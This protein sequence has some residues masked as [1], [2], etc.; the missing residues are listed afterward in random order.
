[1]IRTIS[2]EARA[3]IQALRD[4]L[5]LEQYLNSMWDRRE[6]ENPREAKASKGWPYGSSKPSTSKPKAALPENV[7]KLV[8]KVRG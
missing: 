1:M 5:T 7:T 6:A 2:C 4:G 8:K 3:T